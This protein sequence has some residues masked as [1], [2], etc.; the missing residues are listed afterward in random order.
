MSSKKFTK[1]AQRVLNQNPNV[2]KC[3]EG[4]ISFTDE[5]AV[6]V[7]DALRAG[8]DP[9]QV[10]TDNGLSVRVLGESRIN[11]AIGLWRSKYELDNLPRRKPIYKEKEK[12][13]TAAERRARILHQAI[14]A[15]DRYIAD[16]MSLGLG[17][18]ADHD[19]IAFE[20]ID[21]VYRAEKKVIV[22]DLCSHYGYDYSRYYA[23]I[24][25]KKPKTDE[26]VNILNPHRRSSSDR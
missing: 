22:K 18:G 25:Q 26:F 16:P 12:K 4:K 8:E 19:V 23:Y 1:H 17:E 14:E 2:V 24:Q 7:C 3:T 6:K 11:G 13:E 5:F 10:F 15:C 21:R 9:Y 20:A